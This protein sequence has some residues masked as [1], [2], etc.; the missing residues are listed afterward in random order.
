MIY[1]IGV[2]FLGSEMFSI[3][4]YRFQIAIEQFFWLS[5]DTSAVIFDKQANHK[6]F[7]QYP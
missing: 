3:G 5:E 1:A 7:Q 2:S 4:L 6:V